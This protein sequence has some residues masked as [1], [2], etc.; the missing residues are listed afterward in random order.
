MQTLGCRW[1]VADGHAP[2]LGQA[3]RHRRS[4]RAAVTMAPADA[5]FRTVYFG[6]GFKGITS[7]DQR[8][9]VMGRTIDFL[10]AP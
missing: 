10:L 3:C 9:A 6:F 5:A 1:R 8:N 7:A 4:G 2:M